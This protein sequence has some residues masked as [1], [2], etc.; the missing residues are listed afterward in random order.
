MGDG[1]GDRVGSGSARAGWRRAPQRGRKHFRHLQSDLWPLLRIWSVTCALSP[2]RASA[3]VSVSKTEAETDTEP[4]SEADTE[5]D[6]AGTALDG[7]DGAG[8]AGAHQG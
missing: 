7:V 8:A 2:A 5:T 1:L 4:E 6:R 3:S